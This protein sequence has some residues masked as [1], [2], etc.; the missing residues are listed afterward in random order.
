MQSLKQN[1]TAKLFIS[2]FLAL[3]IPVSVLG[4][5]ATFRLRNLGAY[6][7]N[8]SANLCNLILEFDENILLDEQLYSDET[9]AH[10]FRMQFASN[11]F[12]D[13]LCNDVITVAN[14]DGTVIL[15]NYSAV[16]SKTLTKALTLSYC[17]SPHTDE[18]VGVFTDGYNSPPDYIGFETLTPYPDPNAD[19]SRWLFDEMN[20]N[21]FGLTEDEVYEIYGE[22]YFVEFFNQISSFYTSTSTLGYYNVTISRAED[23]IEF[24]SR[25]Y[26]IIN[27]FRFRHI[28][29]VSAVITSVLS[30]LL[31]VLLIYS[32]S[33]PIRSP[34]KFERI[35]LE[36]FVSFSA[37][38]I[39][40]LV[41]CL[42][43]SQSCTD[44]K[45]FN[46]ILFLLS[47]YVLSLVCIGVLYWLFVRFRRK[48][49]WKYTLIYS[50]YRIIDWIRSKF[51]DIGI[52]LICCVV[53]VILNV[54]FTIIAFKK[55]SLGIGMLILFNLAVI[56]LIIILT[57]QL[58]NLKK[59]A[60]VIADGRTDLNIDS[61]NLLPPLKTFADDLNRISNDME[62]AIEE[63][64]RSE[65]MK[66][67]L[68]TN[69]SHDLKTPL[70][71]IVNY[72]GLLKEQKVEN[73]TA[74]GYIDTLDRQAVRLGRLI[75]DLVEASKVTSGN[76]K[77]E[78]A[79]LNIVELLE[80]AVS[81]YGVRLEQ[82]SISPVITVKDT[83]LTAEADGRLLWRVFDNLLSNACKYALPGTRLYIDAYRDDE[84]ITVSFRNVSAAQLN[85]P[86]EELME[87]FVRGDSSRTT[88]GSGLGLTIAKSLAEV[89]GGT[90]S[91]EIDGDLFK[92][93]VTLPAYK[94]QDML[95]P[96]SDLNI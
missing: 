45:Q 9:A 84:C 33:Y 62:S 35:P 11:Y 20:I 52:V 1:S 60:S 57:A 22:Q 92:A 86:A 36:L 37:L 23:S 34:F 88:T 64:L 69:V 55:T 12:D 2:L 87:R 63:Q 42:D 83:P 39:L 70:T 8:P 13:P 49:W 75:E 41:F 66:T 40:F 89:Q 79:T 31:I 65:R 68:I 74:K 73:E 81:E 90:F 30:L 38:A 93:F 24:L 15:Q 48:D 27:G 21:T 85:I 91:I 4:S 95:S 61:K 58:Q 26:F 46:L 14:P 17:R 29:A 32:A 50:L 28:I 5:I 3:F 82:C 94:I 7:S 96:I 19:F 71:S 80:Q 25:D 78:L 67:D 6:D 51:S 59:A 16:E 76:I 72:V 18:W 77:V 43:K 56:S 44:S 47:A 10:N 53:W 54:F